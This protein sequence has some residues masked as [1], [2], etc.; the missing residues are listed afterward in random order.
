MEQT[1]REIFYTHNDRLIHKWDHYFDIYERYF[2]TYRGKSLNVLEIG[3]SQGGSIQLWKK[4]FGDKLN[5]YSVDINPECKLFE[6]DTTKLYIG[7]QED[8]VF[9]E[10]LYAE[11]PEMDIIMDDGGHSMKQQILTFEH[12]F[13]KVKEG[14]VF[15]VEDTHTSYWHH[16]GGGLRKRG[17]FIEYSKKLIDSLY[18]SHLTNTKGIRVDN[19]TD[20]I[21]SISFYDSIVVFEKGKRPDPFHIKVGNPSIKDFLTKGSIWSAIKTK[22]FR[23]SDSTFRSNFK[24]NS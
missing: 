18:K 12:L 6:A 19:L 3:V 14:G 1:L 11:L 9:L 7:S 4:Y 15:L 13:L 21:K 16:F 5:L 23:M 10:K 22:L 17:S 2:S 20:H 8:P 24:N